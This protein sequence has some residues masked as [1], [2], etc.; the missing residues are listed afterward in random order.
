MC[1]VSYLKYLFVGSIIYETEAK[2][3]PEWCKQECNSRLEHNVMQ[4][5]NDVRFSV[6]EENA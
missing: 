3:I 4:I 1:N 6:V 2:L 5:T